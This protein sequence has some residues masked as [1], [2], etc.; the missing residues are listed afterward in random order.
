[1]NL[2]AL[3][4]NPLSLQR[5]QEP[6]PFCSIYCTN[7]LDSSSDHLGGAV[8]GGREKSVRPESLPEMGNLRVGVPLRRRSLI[9]GSPSRRLRLGLGERHVL[10]E[11][12]GVVMVNFPIS[13]AKAPAASDGCP[14][15]LALL[16]EASVIQPSNG[17]RRGSR[18]LMVSYTY[19]FHFYVPT[20]PIP[21][22][23]RS[24]RCLCLM[25]K[26]Y[27]EPVAESAGFQGT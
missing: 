23:I 21:L 13:P 6:L 3:S 10:S 15:R 24:F 4:Q 16:L 11:L 5:T 26:K 20:A 19:I 22:D 1:M 27:G 14:G 17:D 8:R 25:G 7:F 18:S 2:A 9:S 12:F